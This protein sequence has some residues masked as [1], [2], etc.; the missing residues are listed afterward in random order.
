MRRSAVRNLSRSGTS[1]TDA[2]KISGHLTGSM[3]QRYN[4]TGDDDLE[5]AMKRVSAYNRERAGEIPKIV[6]PQPRR[7]VA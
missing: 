6:P 4:I 5:A 7:K 1:D 2:M 3:F